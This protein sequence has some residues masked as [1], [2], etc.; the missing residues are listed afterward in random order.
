M[1]TPHIVDVNEILFGSLEAQPKFLGNSNA[2][3]VV[4]L[5]IDFDSMQAKRTESVVDGKGNRGWGD[6]FTG[7]LWVNPI[8]DERTEHRA[9]KDV[10]DIQLADQT[11]IIFD[12]ERD[13]GFVVQLSK[14]RTNRCL[15]IDVH[16]PAGVGGFPLS[17][18][19][20]VGELDCFDGLPIAH[21]NNPETDPPRRKRETVEHDGKISRMMS[22][23]QTQMKQELRKIVLAGRESG[24]RCSHSHSQLLIDLS[25][26]QRA[27][28]VACF[29]SFG[30]EP[31]TNVFL[32]H[33]Q[34]DE[35]TTLY[36]PRVTGDDLEW[37]V[38]DEEQIRHPLGMA[39]PVGQAVALES[40]DLMVVPALAADFSG[41]RL[42]RGKGYYDRALAKINAKHTVVVIHDDE[43]FEEI[44]TEE[45]DQ[46]V[47]VI[48]TCSELVFSKR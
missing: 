34:L 29:I 48:C 2:G 3:V 26:E 5:Y 6:T 45:H 42:G 20:T 43:L 46:P 16:W 1:I 22:S 24:H 8:T 9:V 23:S 7:K 21:A 41:Q 36:V 11:S 30:D 32:K 17:K 19:V 44:P 28:T 18:P 14:Q 33:C 40:V 27:K 35:K 47:D 31:N 10:R 15:E 38:F 37:V 12:D 39:E 4:R 25:W 13:S